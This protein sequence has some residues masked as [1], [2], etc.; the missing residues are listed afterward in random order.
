MEVEKYDMAIIIDTHFSE[1]NL[2]ISNGPIYYRVHKMYE[3]DEQVYI[4]L[5]EIDDKT[6]PWIYIVIPAQIFP[7]FYDR[8][9]E[10]YRT[11]QELDLGDLDESHFLIK[12]GKKIEYFVIAF[13]KVLFKEGHIH[14]LYHRVGS[15]HTKEELLNDIRYIKENVHNTSSAASLL[16]YFIEVEK[17][18]IEKMGASVSQDLL[19]FYIKKP[20]GT[21]EFNEDRGIAMRLCGYDFDRSTDEFYFKRA[22]KSSQSIVY[23]LVIANG[24]LNEFIENGINFAQKSGS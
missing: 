2:G 9:R 6:A 15:E 18:L 21:F 10:S 19:A 13:D 11:S 16:P 17:N 3:K 4:I 7:I 22:S 1:K 8:V 5:K 20:D 24:F 12:K 23:T 14:I